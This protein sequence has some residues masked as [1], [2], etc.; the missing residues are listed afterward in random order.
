MS[1]LSL[2]ARRPC[3][4]R[5]GMCWMGAVSPRRTT[6]GGIS[7]W[8]EIC[9]RTAS[10]DSVFNKNLRMWPEGYLEHRLETVAQV[11]NIRNMMYVMDHHR[12]VCV[13]TEMTHTI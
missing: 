5:A 10:K 7:A 11:K 13:Y 9:E 8:C 1:L 12:F 6:L 2:W 3:I 4:A